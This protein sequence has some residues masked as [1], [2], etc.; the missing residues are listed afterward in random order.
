M[1]KSELKTY[2]TLI[3]YVIKE[4]ELKVGTIE[5]HS[6]TSSL[7]IK[8]QNWLNIQLQRVNYTLIPYV[9]YNET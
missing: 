7:K 5:T 2:S 6:S 4:Y 8:F 1:H 9:Y 3:N